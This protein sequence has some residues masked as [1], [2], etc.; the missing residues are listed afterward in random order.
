MVTMA[1][2]AYLK[3]SYINQGRQQV[4]DQLIQMQK[5]HVKEDQEDIKNANEIDK[6]VGAMSDDAVRD[7]LQS[8]F[9]NKPK[10]KQDSSVSTVVEDQSKQKGHGRNTKAGVSQQPKADELL[11]KEQNCFPVEITN[12]NG[13]SLGFEEICHDELEPFS[14]PEVSNN[15]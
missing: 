1:V 7:S 12:D 15:G 13:Q 5:Q 3:N 8:D 11:Q 2:N 4:I 6:T 9:R 10:D 14:V